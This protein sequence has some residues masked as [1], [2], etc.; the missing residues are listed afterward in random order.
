MKPLQFLFFEKNEGTVNCY[1]SLISKSVNNDFTLINNPDIR[2]PYFTSY[3][4]TESH[5]WHMANVFNGTH[6]VN[7]NLSSRG[8][9]IYFMY[10]LNGTQINIY[11]IGFFYL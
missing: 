8:W 3:I 9:R 7:V 11:I 2:F 6:N 1:T 4:D 5:L 10:S